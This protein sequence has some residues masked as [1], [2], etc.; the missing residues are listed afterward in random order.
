VTPLYIEQLRSRKEE[1]GVDKLIPYDLSVDP[2]GL[3]ALRPFE[4]AQELTE[5][6]IA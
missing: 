4:T 1:L 2:T 6:T 5:K 3:P